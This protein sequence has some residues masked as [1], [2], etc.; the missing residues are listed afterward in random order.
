MNDLS[1]QLVR[2][3][4]FM[5]LVVYAPGESFITNVKALL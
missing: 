1:M 4:R 2:H 3:E 5:V